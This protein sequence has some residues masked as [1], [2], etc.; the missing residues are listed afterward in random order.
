MSKWISVKDDLPELFTYC[1]VMDNKGFINYAV[2][3]LDD[4]W[5]GIRDDKYFAEVEAVRLKDS[6]YMCEDIGAEILGVTHFLKLPTGFDDGLGWLREAVS[7]SAIQRASKRDWFD[8]C[9]PDEDY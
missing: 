6:K 2:Y 1:L 8:N 3:A 9:K 5:D 4:D 7:E